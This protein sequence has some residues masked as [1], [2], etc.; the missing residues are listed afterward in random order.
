M[1][2]PQ[3]GFTSPEGFPPPPNA[4]YYPATAPVTVPATLP[5]TPP[6]A[7][8]PRRPHTGV[9]VGVTT[10]LALAVGFG[11][12]VAVWYWNTDA[13]A[14]SPAPPSPTQSVPANPFPAESPCQSPEDSIAAPPSPDKPAYLQEIAAAQ[15]VAV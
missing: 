8:P 15:P 2:T 3:D 10:V 4:A 14:V 5:A 12:G 6:A 13:T 1:S 9:L 11:M 7:L